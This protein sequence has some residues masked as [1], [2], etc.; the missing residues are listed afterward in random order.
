[1][2]RTACSSRG[3]AAGQGAPSFSSTGD[4]REAIKGNGDALA[5]GRLLIWG[6]RGLFPLRRLSLPCPLARA[7]QWGRG[8]ASAVGEATIKAP[9]EGRRLRCC[10]CPVGRQG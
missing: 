2:Q 1:M 10:C 4:P 9:A 5:G 7:S 8:A 3:D 6:A